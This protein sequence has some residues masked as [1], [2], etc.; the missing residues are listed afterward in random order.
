MINPIQLCE[1]RNICKLV[2]FEYKF[3]HT[4]LAKEGNEPCDNIVRLKMRATD[5]KMRLTDMANTKQLFRIIQLKVVTSLNPKSINK[6]IK[7]SNKTY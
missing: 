2:T 3:P 5:G 6:S 7:S 4:M 1:G